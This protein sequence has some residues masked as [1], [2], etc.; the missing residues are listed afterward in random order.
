MR[1]LGSLNLD[2][3]EQNESI[4]ELISEAKKSV[5][6]KLL[7]TTKHCSLAPINLR[8]AYEQF[9]RDFDSQDIQTRVNYF[10]SLYDDMKDDYV[11]PNCPKSNVMANLVYALLSRQDVTTPQLYSS[12]DGKSYKKGRNTMKSKKSSKKW[13]RHNLLSDEDIDNELSNEEFADSP[14]AKE[15]IQSEREDKE[16][17]SD[18][19]EIKNQNQNQEDWQDQ[20]KKYRKREKTDS[21]EESL[22]EEQQTTI[23][24]TDDDDQIRKEKINRDNAVEEDDEISEPQSKPKKKQNK[25]SKKK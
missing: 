15:L 5:F 7:F 3:V 18:Q 17:K 24:S 23:S 14:D 25:K 2:S 1:L 8:V 20:V 4:Q 12:E 22:T 21:K 16:V 19:E 13:S 9:I 6:R 11:F 10:I